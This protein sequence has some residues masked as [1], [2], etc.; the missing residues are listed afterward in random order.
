MKKTAVTVSYDEEKTTAM[1]LYMNQKS[2]KLEDELV[3]A[4]DVLYVKNVPSGVRDF[5]DMRTGVVIET[6]SNK[7]KERG[8]SN[9]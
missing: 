8:A 1:K 7:A 2:M 9:A 4:M 3:K 6:T 5:I